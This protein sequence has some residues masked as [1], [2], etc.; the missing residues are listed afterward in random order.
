MNIADYIRKKQA[1][2]SPNQGNPPPEQPVNMQDAINKYSAMP[3]SELMKELFKE[4]SVSSG[5][6][7]PEQLDNFYNTASAF[8]TEEQRAKMKSLIEQLKRS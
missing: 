5:K 6:V 7:S 1:Q 3:E 4:G 2:S 8:L